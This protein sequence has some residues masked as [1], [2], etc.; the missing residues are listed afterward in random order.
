MTMRQLRFFT[1]IEDLITSGRFGNHKATGHGVWSLHGLYPTLRRRTRQDGWSEDRAL[2]IVYD[3]TKWSDDRKKPWCVKIEHWLYMTEDQ[4][5]GWGSSRRQARKH[6]TR[7][8]STEKRFASKD[9]A[10]QFAEELIAIIAQV[11]S[12]KDDEFLEP[13]D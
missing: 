9:Q 7:Y 1:R 4:A 6:K 13:Q 3:A 10:I 12:R 11:V 2:T 5:T 8:R